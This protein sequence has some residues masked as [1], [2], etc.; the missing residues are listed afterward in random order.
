MLWSKEVTNGSDVL[1]AQHDLDFHKVRQLNQSTVKHLG[2]GTASAITLFSSPDVI[3]NV[4]KATFTHLW[5]FDTCLG[6]DVYVSVCMT[7][8]DHRSIGCICSRCASR[9]WKLQYVLSAE[10]HASDGSMRSVRPLWMAFTEKILEE[11]KQYEVR[12]FF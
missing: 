7:P 4:H 9:S 2:V 1:T 3:I 5:L 6:V 10:H 12:F 11:E 8:C